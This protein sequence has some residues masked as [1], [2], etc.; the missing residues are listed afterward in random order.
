[1]ELQVKSFN[2]KACQRL[3]I[4]TL[5]GHDVHVVAV[6]NPKSL[7]LLAKAYKEVY[8]AAFPIREERESLATWL[9]N[10]KGKNIVAITISIL[11]E[12]LDTP[13]PTIKAMAVGYYY[14]QQDVGLLAYLATA[15]SFRDQGL[16]RTMNN[17]NNEALLE[18]SGRMGKKLKGIFLECNDPAKIAPENDVMNPTTRIKIYE[19]WGAVV[20]P[21]DYIQPPLET[22]GAKCDTLKLLA[23][24]HPDTGK[25]PTKSEIKAYLTGIYTELAEY[26]GMPPEKNPDYL[27]SLRQLDKLDLSKF[28]KAVLAKRAS[29][30]P[31]PPTQG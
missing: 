17:A 27:E 26:A 9:E 14:R 22:G 20:L 3:R 7:A 16:G 28:Y 23:Y 15:P 2:K 25:Y 21:I 19:K 31:K 1:M 8:E 29:A 10:L 4:K 30:K 24:P 13:H 18:F 5:N 11:G 12:N 6:D